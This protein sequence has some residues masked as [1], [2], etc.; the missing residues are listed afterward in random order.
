MGTTTDDV[1]IWPPDGPFD[2]HLDERDESEADDDSDDAGLDGWHEQRAERLADRELEW[3]EQRA[4]A[5]SS[6]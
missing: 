2:Q 1:S 5:E 6:P 4:Y 3:A